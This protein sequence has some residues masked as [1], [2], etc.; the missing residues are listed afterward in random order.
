[1][2]SRR[3][4]LTTGLSAAA[5]C[6]VGYS[7]WPRLDAYNEQAARQRRLMEADPERADLIRMSTLAANSHNTQ[8]W[9]FQLQDRRVIIRPDLSRRTAV[10]D[11]EDHHLYISLGCASENL[12]IAA[13]IHGWQP[14][15]SVVRGAETA[16]S[17]GLDS[18]GA[19]ASDLYQAIPLRQSTRSDYDGC[20][21]PTQDLNTL[22]AAAAQEGVSVRI[23]TDP[24]EM[25]AIADLVV[26]GNGV[27]MDNPAFVQELRDWI[28]FTPDQAIATGDGLF[29]ACSGNPVV[30]EW[31]AARL[32]DLFFQKESENDKYRR[33]IRSSAGIAVF[34]ADQQDAAHWINV[35]RSFQRFALHSTAL[36]IRNAHINQPIEVP[37]LRRDFAGW[38]G[39]ATTRPDLIVR[40]GY[41]PALPMSL[42]RPVADVIT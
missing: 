3:R 33:H 27:Q 15:L 14:A 5:L 38:L 35:G 30:P 39:D 26:A 2:L 31:M 1:M 9:T 6:A 32:F 17:I 20:A 40:F 22:A 18:T 23:V 36:G 19:K 8:P 21:V 16:I 34:T 41:A 4:L 24:S 42:R 29:S 7:M 11:P 13:R 37:E 10:V 12:S 25:D 28:R